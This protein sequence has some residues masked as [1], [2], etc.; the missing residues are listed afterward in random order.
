[1]P[2]RGMPAVQ[3]S[4]GHEDL[5]PSPPVAPLELD[6]PADTESVRIA[7]HAVARFAADHAVDHDGVALAVSEAVTNAV[8]HA[9]PDRL[10]GHVRVRVSVEPLALLIVVSDDGRGMAARSPSRGLG[11]G[12]VLIARLC[13]ALEIDGAGGTR[14]TMRFA[15]G[16]GA[17]P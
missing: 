3:P 1:V 4:R 8:L 12:L 11:V 5:L 9:Y 7:R 2:A 14:L 15:R 13:N 10:G 17:G 16:D 6:L